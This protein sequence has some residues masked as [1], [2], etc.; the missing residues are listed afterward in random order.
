MAR[1]RAHTLWR[2]TA[3]LLVACGSSGDAT[4]DGPASD[5]SAKDDAAVP[6]CD[7]TKP[8]GT[9]TLVDGVNTSDHDKWG[10]QTVDQ[11]TIYF[12]RAPA[13]SDTQNLFV[14]TRAQ[15][16]DAFT[17]ARAID[18]VNTTSN[19]AR[20][21]VSSDGRT[22]YM[23]YVDSAG[24]DI[25]F[26]TRSDTSAEF[27]AQM[28]LPVI[29]G[30]TAD[31]NPW[32]SADGLTM[33]FTSDRDGFNDIFRATRASTSDNFS[34]PMAVAELNSSAGDYMGALSADG[35]EIF[36]GSSRDTN[37]ANDDIFYATRDTPSGPF[38][39]V[40]KIAELSNAATNEYPTWVSADR[41]QLMFTSN[42]SGNYD[43]WIASR[44]R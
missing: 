38:G 28:P 36:I 14:A 15:P 29:N 30:S 37:L 40:M 32:I 4:L 12:S 6:A 16:S 13:G 42:R 34:A 11:R 41:C 21:M 19:E 2:L 43:I 25:H 10:W 1:P 9:P 8:F 33:Y 26:S 44:M 31:F 5:T 23:E 39:A 22:L 35:L 20:P 3:A 18:S 17:D 7:V 24:V 27:S